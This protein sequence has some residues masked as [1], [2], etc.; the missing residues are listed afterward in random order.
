MLTILS[1]A[2]SLN[3][4]TQAPYPEHSLLQFEKEAVDLIQVL[5]KLSRQE[6]AQ[7]MSISPKLA[8]LNYQRFAEFDSDKSCSKQALFAYDGDVY[9]GLDAYSFSKADTEFAQEHLLIVSGLYGLIRPLDLIQAYRLEM[10]IKLITKQ[11][12]NLYQ[13]WGDKL[14]TS[15]DAALRLHKHKVIVN[16]ASNEYSDAIDPAKLNARWLKIDFKEYKNGDYKIIAIHA[17]KARGLM[18]RFIMQNKID[19]P[20]SL[21]AFNVDGYEFN[22]KLSNADNLVFTRN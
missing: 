1:P 11:G 21:K 19:E 16:L 20:E 13:F 17:K 2:K 22:A 5:R 8:E 4:N 9:G 14:T 18:A 15:I 10:S 6:I 12:K 7:L 3:F